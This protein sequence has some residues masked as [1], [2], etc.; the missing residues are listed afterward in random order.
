MK[1]RK[2][3]K[4][5]I[6]CAVSLCLVWV[7]LA[8]VSS[9]AGKP[10]IISENVMYTDKFSLMY[11]V[12]ASTVSGGSATLRVYKEY[13]TEGSTPI[14][15]IVDKTIEKVTPSGG[16]A[17]DCYVFSTAGVAATAF[18]QNFYVTVTDAD[19]NVSD[20]SRY[21][22]AEYLNER[23]YK[24]GIASVT[25]GADL[26][27]KE[28][29]LSTLAFGANA[30][31]VLFNLDSDTSNDRK[32]LVTDYK[33]VYTDLGTVD[34]KFSSGVYAP[35][36]VLTF[37]PF[38]ASKK[39]QATAVL[40]NGADG[41]G[42]K[43]GADGKFT[44]NATAR[45]DVSAYTRGEGK[46]WNEI[47]KTLTDGY[48]AFNFNTE[49]ASLNGFGGNVYE[50]AT[51]ATGSNVDGAA[52]L[53]RIAN[54]WAT[55]HFYYT[56][57]NSEF[58]GDFSDATCKVFEFDYKIS[59]IITNDGRNAFRFD[60]ADYVKFYKNSDGKTLSLGAKDTAVITP[61]EW[62]NIRF[63]F[64]NVDGAKYVQIYVNDAYAYTQTLTDKTNTFNNRIYFYLEAA[65]SVGT[66]VCVDN[67]IMAFVDKAY[68]AK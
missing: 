25:S 20:V 40:A 48:L 16:S 5:L 30:E 1:N 66:T 38:D 58:P 63:E 26:T 43:I 46:Y 11:A 36:T 9:A 21:S 53:T 10:V 39:Y 64:Y 14:Q 4:S 42:V 27:R 47:G 3:I 6:F 17:T 23:L 19:G 44:V 57:I 7:M 8:F 67:F 41:D 51:F 59:S 29:Y 12:D 52:T 37:T 28:F 45:I 62:C 18:T 49:G 55:A 68:A 24:N 33:Y 56:R 22:I 15:T 65:T 31:K 13:P 2:A 50:G 32:Y 54:S 61:G 34:G 60:G 35:E